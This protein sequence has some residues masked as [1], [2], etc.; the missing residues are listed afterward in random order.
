MV[1]PKSLGSLL[2][3]PLL[4]VLVFATTEPSAPSSPHALIN[5]DLVR[6]EIYQQPD[7]T[8]SG[9]IDPSGRLRMPLVGDV[10]LSGLTVPEAQ[11][12]IARAYRDG[13]FLRH[14]HV[15]VRLESPAPREVLISGQ[16]RSPGAY[17]LPA[18]STMTLL[19]LVARAGG[20]TEIARGGDVSRT[21]VG[22]NGQKIVEKF[23]VASLT[24]GKGDTRS[25]T[26]VLQ[27]GDIVFVPERIF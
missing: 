27:P 15:S 12:L 13:E 24:R 6:V 25:P 20:L 17:P 23:D 4:P 3:A 7:L 9:R 18:E 16:V 14:P 26:L 21:R 22:P 19:D 8:V 11:E 2:L 5:G 1:T 10:Q